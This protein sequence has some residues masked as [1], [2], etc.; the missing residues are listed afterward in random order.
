MPQAGLVRKYFIPEK[1]RKQVSKVAVRFLKV[2]RGHSRTVRRN[3]QMHREN[4]HKE[5]LLVRVSNTSNCNKKTSE[6]M[7]L[8]IWLPSKT[9]TPSILW[10]ISSKVFRCTAGCSETC[11]ETRKERTQNSILIYI[12]QVWNL[13]TSLPPLIHWPELKTMATTYNCKGGLEM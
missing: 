7:F 6:T 2:R 13:L 12:G 10:L 5:C 11:Q 3:D 4:S 8:G 1:N 9:Q